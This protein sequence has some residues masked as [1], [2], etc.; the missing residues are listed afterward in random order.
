MRRLTKG[1]N[2]H[3]GHTSINLD[4]IGLVGLSYGGYY[5]LVAPALD[6]RTKVTVCSCYAFVQ[7]LCYRESELSVPVD[8]HFMDRFTLFREPEVCALIRP[9]YLQI[10]AGK[11]DLYTHRDPTLAPTRGAYW[12]RLQQGSSDARLF[13]LLL[14][15]CSPNVPR[16][17]WSP[18]EEW[19]YN[20]VLRSSTLQASSVVY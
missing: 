12:E 16:S 11:T 3:A 1:A 17:M 10:Q 18:C 19:F 20:P 6:T 15:I 5:A 4:R 14:S 13:H 2:D 7:E 9:G 8:F